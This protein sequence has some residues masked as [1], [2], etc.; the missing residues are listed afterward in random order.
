MK[1]KVPWLVTLTA[2]GLAAAL[3]PTL[4]RG[5]GATRVRRGA[6]RTPARALRQ[7][8]P[9]RPL[10]F[11]PNRGQADPRVRYLAHATGYDLFVGDGDVVL[12]VPQAHPRGEPG[13]ASSSA[14]R[15]ELA[16]ASGPTTIEPGLPLPGRVNYLIGSDPGKWQTGIPTYGRV[17]ER[18]V[19]DG[20]DVAWY[21]NQNQVECDFI[22][23]PGA[24][25]DAIE[26]AFDAASV[27]VGEDGSLAIAAG[28]R[29]L[30]MLGP[31]V[32]QQVG[33]SRRTIDG[34]YRMSDGPDGRHRVKFEV[35]AYDRSV[36]QSCNDPPASSAATLRVWAAVTALMALW[37][38]PLGQVPPLS[39]AFCSRTGHLASNFVA[40]T[41]MAS[42]YAAV[43]PVVA[44]LA[45]A[46]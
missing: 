28:D 25:P 6:R 33:G 23:A 7:M 34:R 46:L 41:T 19:W 30:E 29:E 36:G 26:L 2:L 9:A 13:R 45:S 12:T 3:S 8:A 1:H 20:I 37:S 4:A 42:R 21:G 22:V 14:V 31:V 40:Q 24:D 35:A 10:G 38:P 11:E 32:Y 27:A 18:G 15:I 44:S 43:S 17:V 5:R 16:G 39:I